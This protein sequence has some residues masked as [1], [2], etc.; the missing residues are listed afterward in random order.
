[1]P[2]AEGADFETVRVAVAAMLDQRFD[3]RKEFRLLQSAGA[4]ASEQPRERQ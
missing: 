3:G 1:M 4:L 2:I